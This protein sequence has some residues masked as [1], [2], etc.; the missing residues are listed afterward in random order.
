MSLYREARSAR[1]RLWIAAS[2]PWSRSL[3]SPAS[4]SRTTGGTPSEA[5]KLE[6]LQRDV[7]PA[8]AALE[9]IPIHYESPNATTHAA[10]ADQLGVAREDDCV[11][12]RTSSRR[13][14]RPGRDRVLADLAALELL[15]RTT[16]QTDRVERLASRTTSD[17]RALVRLD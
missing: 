8:L 17:L 13:S 14:I 5:E 2:A 12:R 11:G 7:E 16:G 4:S 15:V 3:P 6:S 9:L 10:A 1:R